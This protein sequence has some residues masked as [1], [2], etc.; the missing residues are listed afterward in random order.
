LDRNEKPKLWLL[1]A[2]AKRPDIHL[3][4][5][6]LAW[7]ADEA[8][9]L[10]ECYLESQ[11]SGA[12]FAAQGSTVIGGRHEQSFNYLCAAFDVQ[13]ILLGDTAVFDSSIAAFGCEVIARAENLL[14]LYRE[15]ADLP[16][17]ALFVPTDSRIDVGPYLFP[18]IYFARRLALPAADAS[19]A[20][21][22]GVETAHSACL[23]DS[24]RELVAGVF[25][26]VDE[27]DALSEGDDIGSVTVRIA[28]RW[29][30]RAEG[31]AFGDP[32]VILPQIP[33]HCRKKRVAVYAP[34][35]SLP[36]RAVQVSAYVEETS[37]IADDVSRLAL[38]TGSPVI[39][40]RQTGDGDI[41]RWSRDGLCIQITDPNRPIFP[42]VET[43]VPR[44]ARAG[45]TPP[46]EVD[47]ATL[48]QYADEGKILVS[49]LWHSGE[50]AHNEAMLNVF[51]LA[52][53]TGIKMGI[54]AHAARYETCPQSWEL[55]S[56]PAERGGVRGLIEPLLHSG[57]RGVMAEAECPPDQLAEHCRASMARIREIAGDAGTPTGYYAF[58]DTHLA[59]LAP[60]NEETCAAI[61]SAGL[62]YIVSSALPGRNRIVWESD[63]CIALNQTCRSVCSA[64]PFVRVTAPETVREMAPRIRP[65]WLLATLDAPVVAF[66]PYIWRDG[67]R[68]MQ[69]VDMI[70]NSSVFV[71]VLPRT[72]ARYA[73]LLRSRGVL[74]NG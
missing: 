26:E 38:A 69:I 29:I 70:Q 68:F 2:D 43:N 33:W 1:I 65:G 62:E 4:L 6:T 54:G 24:E 7:M 46:L 58:M 66:S 48:E 40:G 42:V 8:G 13:I 14:D 17:D 31:V 27:I 67:S 73:R 47:D 49:L 35:Q 53:T 18:D 10:F 60:P 72:V 50:V 71:N 15:I 56:V 41:F 39:V 44:W 11:G 57:G 36:P 22:L 28:E 64:S 25:G 3:A 16:R 59:D 12:L 30:E 20:A 63:D 45:D 19:A 55:L 21:E 61:A 32:P 74:P 37:A 34:K 23:S 9:A 5:P 52:A 51:D